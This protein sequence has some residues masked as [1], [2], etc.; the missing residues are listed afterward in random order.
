MQSSLRL[1]AALTLA[2]CASAPS[3]RAA[4]SWT[5]AEQARYLGPLQAN[6]RSTAGSATGTRGAVTVAY[7]AYAARAGLDVLQRGGNA[8]DAALTT[9]ITQVATTAGA[10]VSYFGI[11]SLV[12]YDA[13]SGRIATMWAG[14][15]T[16]RGETSPLTIPGAVTLNSDGE[17]LGTVPHG[18]TAL[19]G[20]FMKGVE[21][22]HRRF[23][24]LP[25]R[26]LFA[27]AIRVADQGMPVHATL[28]HQFELR[29]K[30]LA[31]LP[32]TR[33]AL[34][35]PDG[36]PW[37]VGDTLRQ[38]A[39]AATLRRIAA[40]GADYMYKGPWGARLVAAVQADG[41]VMTMDDL[42]LYDVI[43]S[44][45]TRATVG[46]IE[47]AVPGA[48]N[49][50]GLALIEAQ[51]MGVAAGITRLGHWSRNAESLR[52][53]ALATQGYVLDYFPPDARAQLFPG[54]DFSDRARLTGEHGQALWTALEAGKLPIS[55]AKQPPRHSDDVVVIDGEGNMAAITHSINCVYWGKTAIN[56]DGISIGDP[57]SFQQAAVARAGAGQPLPDPTE[58]G[59]VLK[60]GTPILAFASMGSGLHQRTFQGLLNV[61]GFG[62]S[63]DEA[64]DAPDFFLPAYS[65][66]DSGYV[67]PVIAGRFPKDVLDGA[68]VRYRE[69]TLDRARL[70]GE[71][72]WVAISRDPKTGLL[73]A[74]S[75]NRNNSA[76]LAW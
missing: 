11:M 47:I 41:G 76:A 3:P 37:Q 26:A 61:F 59:L 40:D 49:A 14:W 22:A 16:L 74:G 46:D 56:V 13:K 6:V 64:I 70:G 69:I 62:M 43:W 25:F 27:P 60:N 42:A 8:M 19:V 31:R 21:S 33:A 28:A 29:A 9:A 10:P 53:A 38:P 30:D 35:K 51:Q 54:I 34:L 58:T 1:F 71:G 65:A 55:L 17:A 75:H 15:R 66:K 36:S 68:G 2:A 72:V 32:A 44:D 7:N 20:G 4:E 63:V 24:R 5:E 23:G 67:L 73:R 57:A 50:G 39:L 18:R 12:Y 48:P 45:P 52:R